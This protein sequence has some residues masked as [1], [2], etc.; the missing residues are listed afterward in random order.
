LVVLEDQDR[1]VYGQKTKLEFTPFGSEKSTIGYAVALMA[2]ASGLTPQIAITTR[3][4]IDNPI[5]MSRRQGI[6]LQ[7]TDQDAN[8]VTW[9]ING[10]ADRFFTTPDA[11]QI[12]YDEETAKLLEEELKGEAEALNLNSFI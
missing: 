6:I 10:A 12:E 7:G 9:L 2:N 5:E 11:E 8:P 3:Q 1:V 4:Y